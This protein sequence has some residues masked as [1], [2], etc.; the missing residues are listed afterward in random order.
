MITKNKC[1]FICYP[2][3]ICYYKVI[4]KVMEEKIE[5]TRSGR[6]L[7]SNRPVGRCQLETE[8]ESVSSLVRMA[9]KGRSGVKLSKLERTLKPKKCHRSSEKKVKKKRFFPICC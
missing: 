1:I 9:S 6:L 4:T 3:N 2:K 7:R 8:S 5:G